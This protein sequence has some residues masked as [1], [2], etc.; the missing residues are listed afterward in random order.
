MMG[1]VS[2]A[3]V[4]ASSTRMFSGVTTL[5]AALSR[6]LAGLGANHLMIAFKPAASAEGRIQLPS[7]LVKT[8]PKSRYTLPKNVYS[9]AWTS[10]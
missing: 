1:G 7:V 8:A 5:R 4:A 9:L 3:L 2:P 6:L 10:I